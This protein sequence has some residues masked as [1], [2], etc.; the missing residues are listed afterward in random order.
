MVALRLALA[1]LLA[2]P[3]ASLALGGGS[4]P[5]L[6]PGELPAPAVQLPRPSSWRRALSEVDDP[7]GAGFV[8][9][10]VVCGL[11]LIGAVVGM[12]CIQK[13]SAGPGPSLP[14]RCPP[15][16]CALHRWLYYDPQRWP[17]HS[18][19]TA[20]YLLQK[21][22]QYDDPGERDGMGDYDDSTERY[23]YPQDVNTDAYPPVPG[24][25]GAA[26]PPPLPG[27]EPPAMP[28]APGAPPPPVLGEPPAEYAQVRPCFVDFCCCC[29]VAAH[30][31]RLA[32]QLAV[33]PAC[34]SLMR[35]RRMPAGPARAGICASAASSRRSTA[36]SR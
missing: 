13:K 19:R 18:P 23:S 5:S 36:A 20:G 3:R 29:V 8:V 15:A 33:Q 12:V 25:P 16:V 24:V 17:A 14:H 21:A 26:P 6:T 28:A 9:V 35:R 31:P 10:V 1:C 2:L 4:A 27:A 11:V 30:L 7:I 22:G 32:T 34:S